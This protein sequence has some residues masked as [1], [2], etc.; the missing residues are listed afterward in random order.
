MEKREGTCP[1]GLVGGEG[2]RDLS[3][4]IRCMGG[5]REKRPVH[6]DGWVEKREGTCP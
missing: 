2:R 3:M 5:I 4:R 6:E 1:R